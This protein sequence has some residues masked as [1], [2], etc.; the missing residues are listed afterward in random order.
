[1]REDM[2]NKPEIENKSH[3][4]CASSTTEN[5]LL[6]IK[7][8]LRCYLDNKKNIREKKEKWV[9]KFVQKHIVYEFKLPLFQKVIFLPR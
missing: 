1:M 2:F 6:T 4:M 8:A 5:S 7:Y 9:K 3:F